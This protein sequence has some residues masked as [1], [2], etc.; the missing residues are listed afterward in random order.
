MPKR[1]D[2]MNRRS[3]LVGAGTA[4]VATGA[5][6]ASGSFSQVESQRR[7]TIETVGDEDAY[8][9]LVYGEQTV[10]CTGEIE[11]VTLTNQ[12]KELLDSIEVEITSETDDVEFGD[13]SV[14]ETLAVG[15]SGTVT[16]PVECEPNLEQPLT[17]T[18]DVEVAGA[19]NTIKA[20]QR[21]IE[22]T[23][24]C[25]NPGSEVTGI[26]FVAFCS[27]SEPVTVTDI[28][29]TD[30]EPAGENQKPT[31]ISWTTDSPVNEVVL[32]GG[33]EWYRFA[34][35]GETTGTATMSEDDADEFGLSLRGYDSPG[36]PRSEDDETGS[37]AD[38]SSDNP[39][40]VT[41][42]DGSERRPNSPCGCGVSTKVD[43]EDGTV[44][45]DQ[46]SVTEDDC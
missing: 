17:V 37:D 3:F 8:L 19:G 1:G 12:V 13:L 42:D 40:G 9:K 46:Q 28:S 6:L 20:E 14:P 45:V 25:D 33:R 4:T 36:F 5:V 32:Y 31:G 23:C 7:V 21:S 30:A 38:T 26:D 43:V 35:N 15:E 22:L 41:F 11:L 44:L 27:D 2:A 16:L 29:I 39:F 34:V 24:I 10:D 18:F